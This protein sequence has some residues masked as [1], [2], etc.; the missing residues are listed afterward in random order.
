MTEY[1]ERFFPGKR[2][3]LVL[4]YFALIVLLITSFGLLTIPAVTREGAELVVRIQS[5]NPYVLLANKLQALLGE[6]LAAQLEKVVSLATAT[7]G[8][9]S[10]QQSAE[11]LKGLAMQPDSETAH[12]MGMVFKRALKGHATLAV[13]LISKLLSMVTRVTLHACVSLIFSFLI[14]WDLP[15]LKRGLEVVEGS[16]IG[17]L[18]REVAPSVGTFGA[19]VGKALQAQVGI[20]LVNTGLT[21]AGMWMLE[22]PSLLFLSLIVFFCSFIPVAGVV[23]STIP[24][25]FVA[26]SEFGLGRLVAVIAMVAIIHAVEAYLLNPAIYSAHLKLHPLLVLIVLLLAEHTVGVWGLVLAVPFSVFVVEHLIKRS[27]QRNDSV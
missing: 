16:R 6:R 25:S 5:E 10:E 8:G 14:V 17:P 22:L 21:A 4:A 26:L 12:Q 20:A 27:S 11:V 23:V 19:L 2:R 15:K 1:G 18:Y 24:M 3:V 7:A 13:S 9:A